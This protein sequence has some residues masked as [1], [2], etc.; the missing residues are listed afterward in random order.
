MKINLKRG[1][2]RLWV[3]IS[4]IWLVSFW[5]ISGD[6]IKNRY[7]TGAEFIVELE[8][9]KPAPDQPLEIIT[10]SFEFREIIKN[11]FDKLI[12]IR[13]KITAELARRNLITRLEFPDNN[14]LIIKT[15]EI[16]R[17]GGVAVDQIR[18]KLGPETLNKSNLA[19]SFSSYLKKLRQESLAPALMEF[20]K[21]GIL[22][23]LLLLALGSF[24]FWA[25]QGFKPKS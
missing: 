1:L 21:V 23:P 5:M 3:F 11:P 6:I 17:F 13:D 15:K 18:Y 22:P 16:G 10:K 8:V 2:F 4:A 14:W 20:S 19:E 9:T 7:P 24:L 12:G 25:F